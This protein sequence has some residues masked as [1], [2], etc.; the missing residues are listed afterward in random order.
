M[1]KTDI[2]QTK[3]LLKKLYHHR[4]S[5]ISPE[6]LEDSMTMIVNCAAIYP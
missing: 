3:F 4:A 5:N 6:K 1:T 2:D